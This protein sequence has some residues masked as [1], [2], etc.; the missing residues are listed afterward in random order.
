MA[1]LLKLVNLTSYISP[2]TRDTLVEQ[3][4]VSKFS[5]ASGERLLTQGRT[6]AEDEFMPY[7]KEEPEGTAVSHD[8]SNREDE[9]KGAPTADGAVVTEISTKAPKVSI[10]R[11]EAN[12]DEDEGN[13]GDDADQTAQTATVKAA[14]K[15][16]V[17]KARAVTQRKR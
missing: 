1:K 10:V 4:Q 15:P 6:N 16:A 13:G 3:G 8:F 17:P 14:A 9:D 7:F 12:G 5:D 11:E 2:L